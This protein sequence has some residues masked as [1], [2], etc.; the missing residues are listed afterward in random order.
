M[1]AERL[2]EERKGPA[3][4]RTLHRRAGRRQ[5]EA[6]AV[7]RLV[8]QERELLRVVTMPCCRAAISQGWLSTFFT[9]CEE[10]RKPCHGSRPIRVNSVN[11]MPRIATRADFAAVLALWDE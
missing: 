4:A 1:E 10:N 2:L 9:P 3:P 11:E 6:F 7:R 8:D 5:A